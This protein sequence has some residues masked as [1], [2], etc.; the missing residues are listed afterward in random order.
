[1]TG[2]YLG[3]I[4]W[5]GI[6]CGAPSFTPPSPDEGGGIHFKDLVKKKTERQKIEEDDEECLVLGLFD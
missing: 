6:P 2:G 5:T 3:I 1:M 4:D